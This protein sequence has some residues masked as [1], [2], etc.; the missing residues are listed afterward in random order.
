M[1][2]LFVQV[3]DS[4]YGAIEEGFHVLLAHMCTDIDLVADRRTLVRALYDVLAGIGN[5]CVREAP[6]CDAIRLEVRGPPPG[7]PVDVPAPHRRTKDR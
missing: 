6:I 3:G 1:Q 4:I 5:A 2:T 7:L